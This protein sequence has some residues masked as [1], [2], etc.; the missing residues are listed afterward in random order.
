MSRVGKRIISI[1][2][3]VQVSLIDGRVSITGPRGGIQL[4][5]PRLINL[6]LLS[7]SVQLFVDGPD[8]SSKA[9]HGLY[10]SL[11]QNAVT[12]VTDGFQK[13]LELSGV[14]YQCSVRSGVVELSVGYSKPVV[15]IIPKGVNCEAIDS[16][17]LIVSGVNKQVVGQFAAQ[18]RSSRIPDPYKAKG[19]KYHGEVI[20][21]KAG[22]AF[23]SGS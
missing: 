2:S 10:R 21:R 20:K 19:I 13:R 8:R 4:D 18:L 6:E 1:P 16:T 9:T 7:G 12:G 5:I 3:T 14:G 22:K 11:I 17:H 23:G 15:F